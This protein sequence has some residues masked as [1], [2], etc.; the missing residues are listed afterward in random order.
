MLCNGFSTAVTMAARL[1]FIST[2]P[3]PY[4]MPS[5][6]SGLNGDTFHSDSDQLVPRQYDLQNKIRPSD[7]FGIKFLHRQMACARQSQFFLAFDH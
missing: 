3:R 5:M 7:P 6:I 2:A 4:N 1:P